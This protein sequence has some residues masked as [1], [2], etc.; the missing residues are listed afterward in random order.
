MAAQEDA[1]QIIE[2]MQ[3]STLYMTV[4]V[5][6]QTD[7]LKCKCWCCSRKHVHMLVGSSNYI[8]FSPHQT[9]HRSTDIVEPGAAGRLQ[10]DSI[11]MPCSFSTAGAQTGLSTCCSVHA[12]GCKHEHVALQNCNKC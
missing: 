2:D 7:S 4:L 5:V 9:T 11:R 10:W 8:H 3:V 12:Y 6:I 1:L